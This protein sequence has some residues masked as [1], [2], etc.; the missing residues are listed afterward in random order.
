LA[1]DAGLRSS[2]PTLLIFDFDGVVADSETIANQALADY[3][4]SIGQPTSLDD[5]MRLFMGKRH[6]DTLAAIVRYI[7]RPIPD[8]FE[9][10]YRANVRV[11]MRRDV[12]PIPGVAAFLDQHPHVPKCVASSSSREWLDHCV[13]RFG[14]RPAF[15]D[16]LFSA[17]LV[18]NGKPAPD[19]YLLAADRMRATPPTTIVIEDSPTGV[20]GAVAAGMMVI[21]FLGGSHIRPGHADKLRA[22]GAHAIAEDFDE[23]AHVV[24]RRGASGTG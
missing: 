7:G 20:Q 5:S 19:I 11:V 24:R 13:D 9:T 1:I 16:N 8:S 2:A 18:T 21:G 23:V 10:D 3:L 17:T 4:S 15:G 12:Q 14:F 22:A 6:A